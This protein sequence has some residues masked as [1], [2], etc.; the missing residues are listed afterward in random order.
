MTAFRRRRALLKAGTALAGIG[1]MAPRAAGAFRLLPEQDYSAIIGAA[2]GAD[3]R[4]DGLMEEIRRVLGPG[5]D[6][7]AVRRTAAALDCPWC[8]CRIY[9]PSGEAGGAR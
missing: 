8:G 6:D 9:A 5:T 4:H 7:A 3:P 1:V 2:C